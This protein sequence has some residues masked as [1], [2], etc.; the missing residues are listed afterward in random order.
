[1]NIELALEKK[2]ETSIC[3]NEETERH[4][5]DSLVFFAY[6]I[7]TQTG[8]KQK[9]KCCMGDRVSVR[10]VGYEC[11]CHHAMQNLLFY[12]VLKY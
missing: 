3:M 10:H 5:R 12:A 4:I 7:H 9:Q 6:E 1:M 2:T 8:F 11:D